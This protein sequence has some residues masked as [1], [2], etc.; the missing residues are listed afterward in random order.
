MEGRRAGQERI[1]QEMGET[2]NS[3]PE[4][5]SRHCITPALPL[6]QIC[7]CWVSVKGC[8]RAFP[9]NVNIHG[10]GM[11]LICLTAD[12]K[13]EPSFSDFTRFSTFLAR[14]CGVSTSWAAV[15]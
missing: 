3:D 14:L 11:S 5:Y 13:L 4:K 6:P 15:R 7:D 8:F 10:A 1:D 2:R 12:G 9:N